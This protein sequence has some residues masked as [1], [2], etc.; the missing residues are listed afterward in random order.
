MVAR[1]VCLQGNPIFI[2]IGLKIYLDEGNF[3]E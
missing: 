1:S 3:P 2:K